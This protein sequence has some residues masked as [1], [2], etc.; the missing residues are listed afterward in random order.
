MRE[1]WRRFSWA[2][3]A[4]VVC[5]AAL[6]LCDYA[7]YRLRGSPQ[8]SVPVQRFLAVPLKGNKTE[9]DFQGGGD[10]ACSRSLFGQDGMSACWRL[11]R[12]PNLQTNL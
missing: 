9:Y 3:L 4:L 6:Y 10:A 7:V 11:R 12:H 8:A 1:L 5:A 2:V